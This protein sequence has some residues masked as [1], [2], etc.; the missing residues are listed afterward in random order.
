MQGI[1]DGWLNVKFID[2]KQAKESYQYKNIKRKLYKANAAIWYNK[3][4]RQKQLTSNYISIRING[5]NQQCQKTVRAASHFRISQEIKF[6]YIKKQ[7]LSEQLYNLHLKCA[8]IWQNY[9]H[10]IQSTIDRKLQQEMET[11]YNNLNHKLGKLQNMQHGKNKAQHNPQI[12]NGFVEPWIT[13]QHRKAIKTYWINLIIET[14][15][16]IKLLNVKMQNPFRILAAKKLK[17]ILNSNSHYNATQKRQ[18]YII[19]NLNYRLVTEN[20][21]IVKADKVKTTVIIYSDDY[22]TK[23]HNFLTEKN[24]RH[25]K[26]TQLTNTKNYY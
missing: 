5:K 6:L 21:I 18:A 10:I 23:V 26:K 12:G 16:A 11:R 24:S 4:C 19:K 14:E 9:W 22:S 25:F 1:P 15:Q 17:Q 8:T 3:V 13:T 7:K 2:A 20:A